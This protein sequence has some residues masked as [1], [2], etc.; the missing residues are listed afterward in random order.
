VQ[1]RLLEN[2]FVLLACGLVMG[3]G[4]SFYWP[5][6]PLKADSTSLDKF[7][8]CTTSSLPGQSDA[9]FVLDSVTGR[10]VGGVHNVQTGTF[11]QAWAR[12]VATDFGVLENAQY[13]MASGF[14]RTQGTSGGTPAQSGIYV[15]ELTSGKVWLYGFLL[16]NRNQVSA[17]EL[18]PIANFSFREGK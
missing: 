4:I 8:L 9:V 17:S 16:N 18:V 2:R 6:E 7:S 10:L 11:S 15:A 5:H 14:L 3:L 12:S 1:S 13:L